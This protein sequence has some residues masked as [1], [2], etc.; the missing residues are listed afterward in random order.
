MTLIPAATTALL[1]DGPGGLET[2]LVTRRSGHSFAAGAAVFPGGR[3]DPDD[4]DVTLAQWTAGPQAD[5][6]PARLGRFDLDPRTAMG[7]HLAAIRETFEESGAL[8]ARTAHGDRP[9]P[10]GLENWRDRLQS[11]QA[12]L[13]DLARAENLVFDLDAL[14]PHTRWITPTA[15]PKRFDA[16]FFLAAMP[17]GQTASADRTENSHGRWIEP[18]EALRRQE[19]GQLILFPP[20]LLTLIELARRRDAAE[21]LTRTADPEP[22][23]ILP[24]VLEDHGRILLRLPHDPEYGLE[25]YRRPPGGLIGPSRLFLDGRIWKIPAD[26]ESDP[27]PR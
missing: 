19:R 9:D 16:Q 27:C 13:L 25:K 15:E 11:G 20:T 3:L 22:A 17:V 14:I 4:A 18:A 24:E 10:V 12:A 8:L 2:F 21:A 7:L 1:R 26:N 23:P 6:L 5:Q